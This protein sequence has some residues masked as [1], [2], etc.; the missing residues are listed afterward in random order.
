MCFLKQT[1]GCFEMVAY[2]QEPQSTDGKRN[3]SFD[4]IEVE[5]NQ[6]ESD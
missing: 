1:V 5:T 3:N 4:E 6:S 2:E